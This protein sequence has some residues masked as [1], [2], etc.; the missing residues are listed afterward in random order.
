MLEQ[1]KTNNKF[2]SKEFKTVRDCIPVLSRILDYDVSRLKPNIIH[3]ILQKC[4]K[5]LLSK[6][7]SYKRKNGTSA[8]STLY[9]I[10]SLLAIEKSPIKY[11]ERFI[12]LAL[13]F[14][15]ETGITLL[16]TS[17]VEIPSKPN[18]ND[19]D[20]DEEEPWDETNMEFC[21]QQLLNKYQTESKH[22]IIKLTETQINKLKNLL[23]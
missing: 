14:E 8:E 6:T 21:N 17:N 3:S 15:K 10:G 23:S 2:A 11:E 16:R 5:W 4:K 20:D 13:A 12:D 19:E 1:H 9:Y 18:N 22:Y 7:I